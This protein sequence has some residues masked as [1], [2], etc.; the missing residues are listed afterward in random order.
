MHWYFLKIKRQKGDIY[1]SVA[2]IIDVSSVKKTSTVIYDSLL[3]N[4]PSI[5]ILLNIK[6]GNRISIIRIIVMVNHFY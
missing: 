4:I 6:N 1:C 5:L 2:H 3:Y